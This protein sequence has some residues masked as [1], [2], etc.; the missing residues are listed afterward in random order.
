MSNPTWKPTTSAAWWET[1]RSN[2]VALQAWLYAQYRG[3]ITAGDRIEAL[4]DAF[5]DPGSRAYRV[6]SVVA[7][8]ERTHASWIGALLAA[9]GLPVEVTAK[10]DRYWRH[11]VPEI[12]DLATGAAVGAHAEQMRLER[13]ETISADPTAPPDIRAAFARILPQERFHARAFA[14]LSTSEA[15]A[16]TKDAHALGR[17]ALGL[18]A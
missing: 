11:V 2:P 18:V 1:T 14:S 6:L 16:R 12:S 7:A 5:A 10:P 17:L 15:L 9:R 8:Q 4:R 13:I 3:E